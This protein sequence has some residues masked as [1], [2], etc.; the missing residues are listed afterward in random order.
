MQTAATLASNPFALM[1]DPQ[2]VFAAVDHSERLA[3]LH[4]QVFHPLD[5]PLISKLPESVQAYDEAI[6]YEAGLD[7]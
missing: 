4:R 7:D 5:K 3:R 6:E 2:A 1:L